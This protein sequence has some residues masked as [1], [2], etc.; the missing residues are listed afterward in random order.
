MLHA[1]VLAAVAL[2]ILYGPKDD[3]AEKAAT[4]RLE[5]TVIDRLGL[6]YLAKGPLKDLFGRRESYTDCAK[7]K[8]IFWLL[9]KIEEVFQDLSSGKES[10]GL[11]AFDQFNIKCE[12]FQ[13]F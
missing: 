5:G 6:F 12:A 7:A 10:G 11:I 8:G 3:S 13:L 9:I 1:L 2:V 4:F